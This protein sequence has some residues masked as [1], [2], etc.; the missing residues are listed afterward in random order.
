MYYVY[1]TA[2]YCHYT[3]L[4]LHA[5]AIYLNHTPPLTYH[6]IYY[7]HTLTPPILILYTLYT[8]SRFTYTIYY[9]YCIL[10]YHYTT[11]GTAEYV[12]PEVLNEDSNITTSCDLWA[13]GCILYELLFGQTPFYDTTEF[14]IYQNINKYLDDSSSIQFPDNNNIDQ[15]SKSLICNLLSKDP[16]KR[17]GSA[18]S[19][20]YSSN[21]D[22][23]E[24]SY[25]KLKQHPFFTTSTTTATNTKASTSTKNT[26]TKNNTTNSVPWGA[27]L[28]VPAPFTIDPS[29]FPDS[30]TE[31]MVLFIYMYT[32]IYMHTC[33]HTYIHTYIHA[34]I[35][36]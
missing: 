10:Y 11:T 30:T 28:S 3:I 22:I 35:Q 23:S 27:L 15:S 24:Y 16:L 25:N 7:C 31:T 2:I 36:T 8:S 17:L 21:G 5:A 13:L 26:S 6:Y 4:T 29:T 12:S 20:S 18:G 9:L 32:C 1:T 14:L 34:Y 19:S 33:I